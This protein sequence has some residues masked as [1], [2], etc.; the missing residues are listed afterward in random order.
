MTQ[1][2]GVYFL[3]LRWLYKRTSA[4]LVRASP[5]EDASY[6]AEQIIAARSVQMVAGAVIIDPND[7]ALSRASKLK[8]PCSVTFDSQ[9]A[10]RFIR[11]IENLLVVS[12]VAENAVVV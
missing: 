8:G 7:R 1:F 4:F 3:G 6:L 11:C 9:L 12:I 5:A 10:E 2:P